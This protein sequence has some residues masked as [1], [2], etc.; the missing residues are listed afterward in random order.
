MSFLAPWMFVAGVLGAGV[1]TALHL[2]TTRRPP[3]TPLPTARFV[4]ESEMRALARASRPTDLLL[5]TLR[6]LALL[7]LG[8]AFAKPVLDAPGPR[9]RSV[10]LLEWTAA[11]AEPESA[12]ALARGRL[13]PGDALVVFDTA[14]RV[15]EATALDTLSLPPSDLRVARLSPALVAARDAAATIARGAD[16]LRLQLLTTAGAATL[17][18][19]TPALRAG[20]PGRIE[21]VALPAALDSALVPRIALVGARDDDPLA[22][23]LR[24]LAAQ[25][26][27]RELRVQRGAL[28]AADSAWVGDDAGR[29]LVHW[30]AVAS[31]ATTSDSTLRPDGVAAFVPGIAPVPTLVAPLARG[32]VAPGVV[33]AR[34]RDGTA[35]ATERRLRAGG[36]FRSVGI[37]LPA[38]GDLTLRAPF[39]DFLAAMF[40]PCGG[41]ILPAL[42]DS[43]VAWLSADG[44][45][46]PAATLAGMADDASLTRWLLLV[47]A[48]LLISEQVLRSR[49]SRR[50]A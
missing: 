18:A 41:V 21:R 45:L 29:V 5:L 23:A 16:S 14:A 7:V 34:W 8:A 11:L 10:V 6:A 17:D 36:C 49:A 37:G 25:R 48:A 43:A 31:A 22:P 47:A 32:S 3:S 27:A 13:G 1:I 40:A 2:L 26:G 19:A 20:W 44:P 39:R 38:A 9:V 12:R 30:P 24:S 28:T 46:A 4:P 35:A 50:V 15:V 33:V 42:E